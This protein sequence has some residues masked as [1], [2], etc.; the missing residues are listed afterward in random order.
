LVFEEYQKTKASWAVVVHAFNPRTWEAEAGGFLFY[1]IYLFIY[2]F[3]FG[4]SRQGFS[5]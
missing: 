3:I 4:F 5:V 1:F 2:L